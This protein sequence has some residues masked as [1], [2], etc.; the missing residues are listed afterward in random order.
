MTL[1]LQVCEIAKAKYLIVTKSEGTCQQ[2]ISG[3]TPE[4]YIHLAGEQNLSLAIERLTGATT[5]QVVLSSN[6]SDHD[7]LQ[8]R[9][10]N[11]ESFG[12]VVIFGSSNTRVNLASILP[13]SLE[14]TTCHFDIHN[15]CRVK[16][17]VV[18][19]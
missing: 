7:L 2:L 1:I 18:G 17:R 13:S 14:L 11:L 19:R 12:R 4:H 5:A 6:T 16:P 15:L 10:L 3:G 9:A 8:E